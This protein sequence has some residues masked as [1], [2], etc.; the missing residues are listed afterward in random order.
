[1]SPATSRPST[2]KHWLPGVWPGVWISSTR[3]RTDLDDVAAVV[4]DEVDAPDTGRALHPG[5]LVRL[6]V[7]RHLHLLEQRADPLETPTRHLPAEMIRVEVGP[8]DTGQPHAVG[9]QD[10]EQVLDGVGGVHDD[11][12]TRLRSPMR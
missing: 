6:D 12:L 10:V 7:D 8:E 9:L 11:R 4:G 5:H 1:M 2:R 3:T